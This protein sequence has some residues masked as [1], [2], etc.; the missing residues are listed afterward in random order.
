[1]KYCSYIVFLFSCF[2]LLAQTSYGV[3]QWRYHFTQNNVASFD[4]SSSNVYC[5]GGLSMFYYTKSN[6]SIHTVTKIDGLSDFGVTALKNIEDKNLLILGYDNGN[7]D[8]VNLSENRFINESVIRRADISGSKKI[9]DIQY[10]SPYIYF[11]TDFGVV[12]Y[13]LDKNEVKETYRNIGPNGKELKIFSTLIIKD[14]L[15][16]NSEMGLL[17]SDLKNN[18][19]LDFNN[20][21]FYNGL[22]STKDKLTS[23][24]NFENN[25]FVSRTDSI[26][27]KLTGTE[28]IKQD[29]Y[30]G[31]ASKIASD[32]SKLA[33][34]SKNKI[35]LFNANSSSNY[36]LKDLNMNLLKFY[37]NEIWA[38]DLYK[39]LIKITSTT[40]F[41]E[42]KPT[43]PA[44]NTATNF[45]TSNGKF[46]IFHGAWPNFNNTG[47]S[48]LTN[49]LT[50]DWKFP[51]W[52][53]LNDALYEPINGINY[54]SSQGG[55]ILMVYPDGSQKVINEKNTI[56]NKQGIEQTSPLVYYY[57]GTRVMDIGLDQNS[58][59][60][61]VT[62]GFPRNNNL[63]VLNTNHDLKSFVV[64]HTWM[65][66]TI[67]LEI[68][69]NG[70]VW[71]LCRDGLLVFDPL[72][73]IYKEIKSES[74]GGFLHAPVTCL[75]KDKNGDIWLGTE[76]GVT[77]LY[78]TY[79]VFGDINYDDN[80]PIL[81]SQ[82]LLYDESINCI[83][84]DGGNRK[85]FGSSN[86]AWLINPVGTEEVLAFNTDNSPLP[87]N[88]VNKIGVNEKDGEVFFGLNEGV[89]SYWG[90]ATIAEE[91]HESTIKIFPNPVKPDFNGTI[92][93]TG[94]ALNAVVKITD[95]SG[96]L[97]YQTIANGGMATWDGKSSKGK[98]PDSGVYLVYSAEPNGND[99]FVGKIVLFE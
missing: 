48:E 91:K 13:N 32:G 97:V 1:M 77:V 92:G 54:F 95:V 67:S 87:S 18:N 61:F 62:Y 53:G 51:N 79:R 39:G 42:I 71:I 90:D 85:W 72:N 47:Y 44:N 41:Q 64:S 10:K 98:K 78:D 81:N 50:W 26:V 66:R 94:L 19:L 75:T 82:I 40:E 76:K 16:A 25:L 30:S 36:E 7:I 3:G 33:V 49:T 45:V 80:P 9:N 57:P 46:M 11:S 4:V 15:F 20:W 8:F 5:S 58:N 23:I 83:Y 65:E 56:I 6:N 29:K 99:A 37:N 89:V 68:D 35:S 14:S 21:T 2:N 70:F 38:G 69:N 17:G 52:Y 74:Q 22:I 59:L 73:E 86:G 88:N 27:F 43:G 12:V 24:V 55:G 31:I 34:Y 63:F 93:I 28:L 84:V 96:N 60:W